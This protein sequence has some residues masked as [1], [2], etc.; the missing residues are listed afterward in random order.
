MNPRTILLAVTALIM[1]GLTAFLVQG[2]I[3]RQRAE[4]L[5]Q[6]PPPQLST[7]QV[8]VAKQDLPAGTFVKVEHLQWRGWPADG[9]DATFVLKGKG[10][11]KTFAG[12]VV[13]KGIVAGEP[14]TAK[15][16]VKPGER[17]F[18]A[19]VMAPGMRGISVK[20]TAS[21]GISGLVF[22]GDRVDLILAH[23][24]EGSGSDSGSKKRNLRSASE[25]VLTNVRVL[26][27]GQTINDQKGKPIV[28]KTATLEVTPKQVEIVAVAVQLGKLSLSLRALAM[29]EEEMLQTTPQNARANS[30]TRDSDVSRLIGRKEKAETLTVNV[31]HGDKAKSQKLRKATR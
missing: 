16:V 9:I 22:P 18:L 8:L 14:I 28:A 5:A 7:N 21:S 31:I 27:V 10:S 15:R 17:G 2:W 4:L 1:A 25:T 12:A 29:S 6:R 19:A 13:R 26:A 30:F 23:K 24:F 3:E 20:V 11:M